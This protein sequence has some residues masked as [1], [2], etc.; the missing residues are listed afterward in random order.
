MWRHDRE[1]V[2]RA[3]IGRQAE[4]KNYDTIEY[5]EMINQ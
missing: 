4:N 1:T 2:G 3:L 5:H